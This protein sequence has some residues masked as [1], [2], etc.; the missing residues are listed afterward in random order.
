MNNQEMMNKIEAV[1]EDAKAGILATVDA[2]GSPHVRW[3]TPV[4]LSQWPDAI[5]AVTSPDFPKIL[6]LDS[7]K[8]VEWMI[9]TRALDQIIN[10]RG[11][12]NILDN[13]SLKAQVM[14]AI[15]KK[16]TVFWNINKQKT[17]FVILETVI[18]EASWFAPM[19][20]LREIVQFRQEG[21][22]NE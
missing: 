21:V 3:M 6:Q 22:Q 1:L 10:V 18:E 13:P 7:N 5:F 2:A 20:D 19:K 11:G 17:D 14:E 9:Q 15:G 12:I 4:I 8:K 16:L